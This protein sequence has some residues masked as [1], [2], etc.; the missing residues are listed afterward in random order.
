MSEVS[1]PSPQDQIVNE[2]WVG[3]AVL[4]LYARL[5]ILREDGRLGGE[6]SVRM[7]SNRFLSGI[8]E[9]TSV[10]AEVGRVYQREGL[11]AAFAWIEAHLIPL[12]DRQEGKRLK[13]SQSRHRR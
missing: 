10:E 4:T 11:Q 5:K 8:G 6:K 1:A 2:A 3:D 9:P 7:T 13:N 12:F